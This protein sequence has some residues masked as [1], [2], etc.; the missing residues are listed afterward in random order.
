MSSDYLQFS[1]NEI[2]RLRSYAA[3]TD[4]PLAALT[5]STQVEFLGGSLGTQ[6]LRG[7]IRGGAVE[8]T[9]ETYELLIQTLHDYIKQK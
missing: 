8:G 4:L 5:V 9:R 7:M 6:F 2:A 3:S 1:R